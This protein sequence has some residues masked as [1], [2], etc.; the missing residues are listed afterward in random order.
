MG[1]RY[2]CP[3]CLAIIIQLFALELLP[4]RRY[5]NRNLGKLCGFFSSR[6]IVGTQ[7]NRQVRASSLLN[8]NAFS[9]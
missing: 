8:G 3:N 9:F 2:A 5:N 6:G 4:I 1:K 7:P